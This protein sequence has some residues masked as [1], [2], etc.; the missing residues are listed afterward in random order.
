MS[1][2]SRSRSRAGRII[3]KK[4]YGAINQRTRKENNPK[5]QE[6]SHSDKENE[7]ID[8]RIINTKNKLQK[9]AEE[10]KCDQI[11]TLTTTLFNLIDNKLDENRQGNSNTELLQENIL[12]LETKCKSMQQKITENNTTIEHLINENH[13]EITDYKTTIK[14]LEGEINKLKK[15]LNETT[16]NKNET[17][18][19]L[20]DNTKDLQGEL[21]KTEYK[22]KQLENTTEINEDENTKKE[23]IIKGITDRNNKLCTQSDELSKKLKISEEENNELKTKLAEHQKTI[24]ELNKTILNY[25]QITTDYDDKLNELNFTMDKN[26]DLNTKTINMQS[27]EEGDIT[28]SHINDELLEKN[29]DPNSNKSNYQISFAHEIV[30]CT[31]NTTWEETLNGETINETECNISTV[32]TNTINEENHNSTLTKENEIILKLDND[33]KK[34]NNEKIK[35]D[36][37]IMK[38]DK[39]TNK[40]KKDKMYT[41]K[42]QKEDKNQID[43]NEMETINKKK[44]GRT[45]QKETNETSTERNVETNPKQ[46]ETINNKHTTAVNNLPNQSKINEKL[47]AL[48]RKINVM[49]KVI[50]KNTYRVNTLETNIEI[51]NTETKSNGTQIC[52]F[53][54]DSHLRYMQMRFEENEEFMSKNQIKTNFKPGIGITG[55]AKLIPDDINKN[56]IIVISVG[57]NDIYKTDAE[58]FEKELSKINKMCSKTILISIPPQTCEKTNQ[59]IVRLNTRIRHFCMQNNIAVLNTHN[60]IKPQHLA[61][62]GIH[63][64]Q[65]A[66]NWLANKI[67]KK[68]IYE[69]INNMDQGTKEHN[70]NEKWNT[71][72]RPLGR[73]EKLQYRNY[74]HEQTYR[75]G[76]WITQKTYNPN[77]AWRHKQEQQ[78]L[79]ERFENWKKQQQSRWEQL[80][81][82]QQQKIMKHQSKN[83][84][85]QEP[86]SKDIEKDWPRLPI[87][88]TT[89]PIGNSEHKDPKSNPQNPVF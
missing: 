9:L 61:R 13:E 17:I 2:N 57:T 50:E 76:G 35:T 86:I 23:Q 72:N 42:E 45:Q 3:N 6:D 46:P 51:K 33:A 60:F 71:N 82:E 75:K 14:E 87:K 62:D 49:E 16:E 63:L 31:I 73:T 34:T 5:N 32:S 19:E 22:L 8:S 43:K 37:K 44:T 78:T 67:T 59:D 36:G 64:G 68:I 39:E 85:T 74:E 41:G 48:E 7:D 38:L 28:I 65:K 54:G 80:M 77:K 25:S 18:K 11:K 84:T 66:K 29:C 12:E 15:E 52:H 89:N 79:G 47:T 20:E 4:F 83:R 24:Y 70:H 1:N 26:E 58:I 81:T 53:I 27:D 21:L 69:N 40:T 55:I 56:D 30:N 88:R 10:K